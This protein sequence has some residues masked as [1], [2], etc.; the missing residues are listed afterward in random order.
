[1]PRIAPIDPAEASGRTKELLDEVHGM[2]GATPNLFRTAAASPA[3]LESML[4]QFQI[5]ANGDID[6]GLGEQ[7]ALAVAEVNGCSYCL[8][9]HTAIGK[10]YGVDDA[11]LESS[12][13]A[14]SA[15]PRKQAALEFAQAVTRERGAVSDAG[16]ARVRAAGW[17]DPELAEIL[18]HVA[19]NT[20]T[21]YYA[22]ATEIEI[23]WPV[24][25]AGEARAA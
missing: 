2:F 4:R 14:V 10:L 7:I 22:I 24:V 3:T 23:D 19:L 5:L 1:M 15:D 9:A 6:K 13:R 21:N 18:A 16:F 20:F 8:S 12:R 17:S 25:R 11:E